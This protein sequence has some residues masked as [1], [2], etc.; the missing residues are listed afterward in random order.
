MQPR[1]RHRRKAG[2]VPRR[3]RDEAVLRRPIDGAPRSRGARQG[4]RTRRRQACRRPGWRGRVRRGLQRRPDLRGSRRDYGGLGGLA[5]RRARSRP[6]SRSRECVTPS[7]LSP[8]RLSRPSDDRHPSD[9]TTRPT[10]TRLWPVLG[11]AVRASNGTRSRT[12]HG[13]AL[14]AP[15]MFSTGHRASTW[16][17]GAP[18]TPTWSSPM[19]PPGVGGTCAHP[20]ATAAW[21]RRA[22]R[23]KLPA[24]LW[25][26][27]SAFGRRW[28]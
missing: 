4:A 16:G 8:G 3:W 13:P 9:E 1:D 23:S 15:T 10:N 24:K 25:T 17:S 27:T 2:C 7:P 11:S 6:S 14:V 12:G 20:S 5:G 18:R 19:A 28:F 26:P 21:W 22:S